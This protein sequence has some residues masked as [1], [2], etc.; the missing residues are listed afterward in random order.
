MSWGVGFVGGVSVAV[1]VTV[2][3][4]FFSLR[5]NSWVVEPVARVSGWPGATFLPWFRHPQVADPLIE[6]VARAGSLPRPLTLKV[7]VAESLLKVT[8]G[9]EWNVIA[10]NTALVDRTSAASAA[11]VEMAYL[12]MDQDL[13]IDH[14]GWDPRHLAVGA[15]G[16]VLH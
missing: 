15:Y 14:R 5:L 9:P 13:L 1:T 7:A 12:R 3:R 8:V 10:A 16:Y 2:E 11:I 4:P 6:S